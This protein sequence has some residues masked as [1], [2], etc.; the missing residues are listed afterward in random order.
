[1]TTFKALAMMHGIWHTLQEQV[2]AEVLPSGIT[3]ILRTLPI[4]GHDDDTV[5]V[6]LTLVSP[7]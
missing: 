4:W 6:W 2:D 3:A 5:A 7:N 1:M